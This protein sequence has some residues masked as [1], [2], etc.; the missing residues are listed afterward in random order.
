MSSWS[1]VTDKS[2]K[3]SAA[4]KR[5]KRAA[6]VPKPVTEEH[7]TQFKWVHQLIY[8]LSRDHP[9]RNTHEDML[10]EGPLTHYVERVRVLIK[11][12]P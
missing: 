6:M 2:K 3:V 9:D 11:I 8:N 12:N 4:A 10:D 7:R 1:V 5:K